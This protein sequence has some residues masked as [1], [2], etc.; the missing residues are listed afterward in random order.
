M[1]RKETLHKDSQRLPALPNMF[2]SFLLTYQFCE[3]SA[4]LNS[5]F[6]S[7][8]S[9]L[10]FRTTTV[11]DQRQ[12]QD[13]MKAL[14]APPATANIWSRK[15]YE[16]FVYFGSATTYCIAD[17]S[18]RHT[19]SDSTRAHMALLG[20]AATDESSTYRASADSSANV[21]CGLKK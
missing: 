5:R 3:H 21:V 10:T 7:W 8:K 15:V 20:N 11:K 17:G 13:R 9:L 16:K 14:T 1:R 19:F 6:V 18:L 12:Q 2:R 4:K